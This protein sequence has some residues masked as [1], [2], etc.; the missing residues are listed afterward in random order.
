M[1]MTEQQYENKMYFSIEGS[2]SNFWINQSY[3]YCDMALRVW[4]SRLIKSIK[5]FD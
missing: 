1:E 3:I 2:I 4:G 5:T